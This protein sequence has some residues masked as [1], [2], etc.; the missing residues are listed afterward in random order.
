MQ[1]DFLD[2]LEKKIEDILKNSDRVLIAVVGKGGTGKSYFGKH[3]RKRGLGKF[4][5]RVI[6]V[7]DDGLMKLEFLFFFQRRVKI[8]RTGVDELRPFIKKMPKRIKIIFFINA[9][10]WERITEAD[11]LLKLSTD[12]NTRRQRLQQR[13]GNNN[14]ET[15]KR[16]LRNGE[17]SEYN[18]K[19]SCLLEAMV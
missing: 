9:T 17:I 11:I 4:S 15:L 18:I 1:Y 3:I 8:P 12:E 6:A 7:I 2:E 19:Y 16:I 5:K 10:P 14:Y 13:Y